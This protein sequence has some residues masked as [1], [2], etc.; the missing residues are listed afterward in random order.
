MLQCGCMAL[1]QN[2]EVKTVSSSGQISL[3]K[4]FAGKRVLLE[5][6]DDGRWIVTP[7]QV[8]PDHLLWAHSDETTQ[9]IDAYLLWK[10]EHGNEKTNLQ[11]FDQKINS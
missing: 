9:Q 2:G 7:V 11:T 5:R 6:L 10:A 1:T 4:A 3:G 8:I